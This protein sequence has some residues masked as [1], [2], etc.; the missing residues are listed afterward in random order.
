MINRIAGISGTYLL[1]LALARSVSITIG[2]LG[3]FEF[4]AGSYYYVGSAFG[5]G[6]LKARIRHHLDGSSRLHWH[7]DYL[8]QKAPLTAVWVSQ[9]D[10]HL[11][12]IWSEKMC[13]MS[14]KSIPVVGFGSSACGCDTHL[15]CLSGEHN[16]KKITKCLQQVSNHLEYVNLV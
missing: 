16:M 11:E 6:G 13:P 7:I 4:C 15:F 12:H 2:K 5:P 9:D 3:R 8:R 1:Q 10:C 14:Q